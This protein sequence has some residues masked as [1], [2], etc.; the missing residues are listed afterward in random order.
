MFRKTYKV[1]G[2]DVN[3]FMV[4]QHFAYLSY[5]S[6]V[7]HTFLFEKGYS[8]QKLN[9]LKIGLQ[10]SSEELIHYKHLMFGQAFF[11]DLELYLKAD[12]G[13][14]SIKNSFFNQRNELC[15][16]V[17][18]KLSWFDYSEWEVTPAPK[19]IAKHFFNAKIAS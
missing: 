1:K 6:N 7:L 2:E 17:H 11:V 13:K 10:E 18:T 5:A 9:T 15:T 16:V 8:R 12:D 14:I 19:R 4:M 3:D